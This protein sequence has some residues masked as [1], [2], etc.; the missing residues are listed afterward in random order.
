[1]GVWIETQKIIMNWKPH[2]HTLYGC[3]DWNLNAYPDVSAEWR[4]TLY[5]CVDWNYKDENIADFVTVTPCMGVWI[6]TRLPYTGVAL[7]WSHPVWVCGLKQRERRRGGER[8]ES[9]PVW[10]CG[11]KRER[12]GEI[13]RKAE[14]HPVWV[15]GLKL[16]LYWSPY[17]GHPVTPCMGVWIETQPW[18]QI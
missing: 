15:C 16:L 1:M 13:R 10:V 5:G 9:H 14:S 17:L 11:L 6:E 18:N 7:P 12:S 4:H 2:S 8:T 3:V